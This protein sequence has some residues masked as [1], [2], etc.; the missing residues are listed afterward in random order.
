MTSI[1]VRPETGR[2][3]LDFYFRGL[4]C[5]EQ[6]SYIDMPADRRRAEAL[7]RNLQVA[8]KEDSFRYGDFFPDSPKVAV[9]DG[10]IT[11]G[12]RSPLF[13]DFAQ[14]W[15]A[16]MTPQWSTIHLRTVREVMAKNL[17]P[18]FGDTSVSAISR[19]DV[20]AF[21]AQ[22]ATLRGYKGALTPS[23]INK[24]MC[25]LRQMLNEAALRFEFSPAFQ[26]IKP[27]KMKRSDAKPFSLAE[28]QAILAAIRPDLRNY[29]ITRFFSGL[30]TGEINGLRW[31]N[32]DRERGLILV[33]ET[34]VIGKLEEGT[35]T[36]RSA[37][38]VPMLPMVRAA[39]EIQWAA[40]DPTCQWV[41][42]TRTGLPINAKNFNNRIWLPLLKSLGLPARRP[43]QTRHTTATLML[44]A[45]ENPEW[46][47]HIL[48]HA[49]TQMLFRVYS[50]F[51]PNLTRNDGAAVAKLLGTHFSSDLSASSTLSDS[52]TR[53]SGY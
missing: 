3:Y 48:G 52:Q 42:P 51:I 4:R 16:E 38:D 24:I 44:G 8:M 12:R 33:R 43:Y 28:V 1:R 13:R 49:N 15:I 20:L 46:V 45:G 31:E 27:L 19:A 22:L 14:T 9:F 5:R 40:R 26:G 50:R 11:K 23:R 53:V 30:R 37:R 25:F 41:F 21:R 6:T 29:L 39:L 36:E 17:L 2:L 34:L 18:Q 10:D 7:L 35:K 47:A 32:V